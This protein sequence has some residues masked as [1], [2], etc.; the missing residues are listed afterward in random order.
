VAVRE[1]QHSLLGCSAL[2]E[3]GMR[4]DSSEEKMGRSGFSLGTRTLQRENWGESREALGGSSDSKHLRGM[5]LGEKGKLNLDRIKKVCSESTGLSDRI[6]RRR[7][8]KNLIIFMG[9][10]NPTTEIVGAANKKKKR[11]GISRGTG[12]AVAASNRAA[13]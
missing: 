13:P 7:G 1:A 11:T 9:I 8:V 3:L 4:E 5:S 12:A 10:E 2:E 6:E